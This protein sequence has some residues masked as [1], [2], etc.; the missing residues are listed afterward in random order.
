MESVGATTT[1]AAAPLSDYDLLLADLDA[2]I[3][4]SQLSDVLCGVAADGNE[5]DASG[6]AAY[7]HLDATTAASVTVKKL[8]CAAPGGNVARKRRREEIYA[9]RDSVALLEEEL[10]RLRAMQVHESSVSTSINS[11]S[12]NGEGG[13]DSD[14]LTAGQ[15]VPWR[16]PPPATV[17]RQQSMSGKTQLTADVTAAQRM[18]ELEN[19][20]LR[21]L[22]HDHETVTQKFE[23][24]LRKWCSPV[25]CEVGAGRPLVNIAHEA[26]L[27][28]LWTL[29][30][31]L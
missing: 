26:K 31:L 25:V 3:E 21:K 4:S 17:P 7:E 15:S 18:T 30:I 13:R 29:S 24:A 28:P 14:A 2:L 20:H 10:R 22:V 1:V 19:I 11:S 5:R 6:C 16:R 9:L 23:R 8:K 12:S 27:N